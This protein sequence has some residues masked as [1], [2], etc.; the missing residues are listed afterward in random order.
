MS[1][2]GFMKPILKSSGVLVFSCERGKGVGIERQRYRRGVAYRESVGQ[3][4]QQSTHP[5]LTNRSRII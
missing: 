3:L 2:G 4:W 5:Q 1:V